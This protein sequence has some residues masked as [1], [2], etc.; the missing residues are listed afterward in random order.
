MTIFSEFGLRGNRL[1]LADAQTLALE[2]LVSIQCVTSD[3]RWAM[4]ELAC[5]SL[6]AMCALARAQLV[7]WARKHRTPREEERHSRHCCC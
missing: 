6:T 7:A 5:R 1:P 2:Q 4:V 3:L